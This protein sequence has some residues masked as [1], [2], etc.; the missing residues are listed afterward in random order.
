M[1]FVDVNNPNPVDL[2]GLGWCEKET[3]P[4]DR[5]QLPC[6]R[7]AP[8]HETA[9]TGIG[10]LSQS[11]AEIRRPDPEGKSRLSNDLEL[12]VEENYPSDHADD[13]INIFDM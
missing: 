6:A 3:L 13:S 8:L 2:W 11:R 7:R 10:R 12:S 9:R 4:A 5:Y 1:E